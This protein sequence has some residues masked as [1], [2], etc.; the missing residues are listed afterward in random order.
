[1]SVYYHDKAA[2]GLPIISIVYIQNTLVAYYRFIQNYKKYFQMHLTVLVNET[3]Y[4]QTKKLFSLA[5]K[6]EILT[7]IG[8]QV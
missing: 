6:Q 4:E 5:G 2:Q 3:F 7:G 1:M 8:N